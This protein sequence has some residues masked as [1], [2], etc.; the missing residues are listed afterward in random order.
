MCAI[1]RPFLAHVPI[2]NETD[3]GRDLEHIGHHVLVVRIHGSNKY[4]DGILT[5]EHLTQTILCYRDISSVTERD[6][7]SVTERDIS[8]V[9]ERD[10]SSVTER[11][12]SSVTERDISSVTERDISSITERGTSVALQSLT[13]LL[14]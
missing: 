1:Q 7:S 14:A 6:I 9:T 3:C 2:S 13:N 11:D 5:L 10:I 8:S 4:D 12:I